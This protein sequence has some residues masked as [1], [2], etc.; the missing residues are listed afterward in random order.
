MQKNDPPEPTGQYDFILKDKPKPKK[1]LV[2]NLT[3]LPRS[4]RLAIAII[5]GSVV[6]VILFLSVFGNRAA[7]SDKLVK[8]VA[9]AQEIVRVDTVAAKQAKSSNLTTLNLVS[10]SSVILAS[11][12][13]ELTQYL[14]KNNIK[15]SKAKLNSYLNKNTD[16]QLKS[17]SQNNNF[18]EAYLS[19]LKKQ[20]SSYQATLQIAY[21][22]TGKNGKVILSKDFDSIK[23][24]LKSPQLVSS[25]N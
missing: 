21:K 17:A 16:A 24:L 3:N 14:K 9:Q 12:Q 25:S 6:I 18:D 22:G 1:S 23:T 13:T 8:I 11:Q 7:G 10:T 4:I 19:Y 2:P 20:L 5:L 15:I